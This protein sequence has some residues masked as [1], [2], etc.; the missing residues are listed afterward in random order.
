MNI[1]KRCIIKRKIKCAIAGRFV[2]LYTC[3]FIAVATLEK[4]IRTRR[5]PPARRVATAGVKT[6]CV[7]EVKVSHLL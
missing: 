4:N 2:R 5:E 7:A 3:V 6:D 1:V